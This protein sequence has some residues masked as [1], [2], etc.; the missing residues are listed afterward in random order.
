M[1]EEGTPESTPAQ[2]TATSPSPQADS[3]GSAGSQGP[4]SSD[5][6]QPSTTQ[7]GQDNQAAYYRRQA[8]KAQRELEALRKAQMSEADRTKAERDE[9][10]QKF[11]AAEK[12]RV[13]T[14]LQARFEAAAAKAGC[15]DVDAAFALADRSGLTVDESGR[16]PGVEKAVD[17]LKKARPYLFAPT[18]AQRTSVGSGGGNPG[19]GAGRTEAQLMNSWLRGG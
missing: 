11:E 18:P 4:V 16:V 14:L 17:A 6:T 7:G 8:E 9:Y 3:Q 1:P 19:S 2:G 5:P 13:D 15:V 10:R 12:A